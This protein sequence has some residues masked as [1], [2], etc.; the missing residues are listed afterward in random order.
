MSKKRVVT[1][2]DFI[3]ACESSNGPKEVINALG[4]QENGSKRK[5]IKDLSDKW[6][7]K[8]P[9]YVPPRKYTQIE[10]VCPVCSKVFITLDGNKRE[11][12]VCSHSCSNTY[13][14]SGENNGNWGT[15]DYRVICFRNQDKKCC[16]CGFTFIVEV[17]HYDHN[18]ENNEISNLIP[19]C[20]NH[21]A[22]YHSRHREKV[23]SLIDDYQ[24]AISVQ[25]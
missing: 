1:K 5:L 10:K 7:V 25:I 24:R 8:I 9:T 20:P 15:N 22:M 13:F 2:E 12:T 6:N 21:H 4:W 16:I 17:H 18:R 19:L 23:K 14:R 3:L 11:K